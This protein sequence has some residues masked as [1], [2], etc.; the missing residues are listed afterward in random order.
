MMQNVTKYSN[1]KR[2]ALSAADVSSGI[3]NQ[4]DEKLGLAGEELLRMEDEGGNPLTHEQTAKI[5]A[6]AKARKR[7]K[8]LLSTR[9]HNRNRKDIQE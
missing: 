6:Y 3:L 2:A 5:S 1:G 9:K 7:I 4:A 8:N